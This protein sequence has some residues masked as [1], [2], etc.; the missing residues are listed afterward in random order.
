MALQHAYLRPNGSQEIEA[1]LKSVHLISMLLTVANINVKEST[2]HGNE[3]LLL[4]C[5][6]FLRV[7]VVARSSL[8]LV[9]L[10]LNHD[11]RMMLHHEQLD[12]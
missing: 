2:C 3:I 1:S 8:L 4:L 10:E 7:E 6:W 11:A 12:K 9:W 5:I